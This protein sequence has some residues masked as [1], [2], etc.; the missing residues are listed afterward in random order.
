M[1]EIIELQ[2]DFKDLSDSLWEFYFTGRAEDK[3]KTDEY[4][5]EGE[6]SLFSKGKRL[7]PEYTA[8]YNL[9]HEQLAKNSKVKVIV[10]RLCG[11][12]ILSRY[13][14]VM[15]GTSH[16][17]QRRFAN[18]L[19]VA[20]IFRAFSNL[21]GSNDVEQSLL[22]SATIFAQE[23]ASDQMEFEF[24]AFL[25][26]SPLEEFELDDVYKYQFSTLS[27]AELCEIWNS[28]RELR[29]IF[30]TDLG[31][32]FSLMN[33]GPV[34]RV[35]FRYEKV[36]VKETEDNA[37]AKT[38]RIEEDI[39]LKILEIVQSLRV[40]KDSPIQIYAN[41]VIAKSF[42][43]GFTQPRLGIQ[44]LRSFPLFAETHYSSMDYE[45]L[46]TMSSRLNGLTKE[47]RKLFE[48]AA[49]RISLSTDRRLYEDSLIDLFIALEALVLSDAGSPGERSELSYRLKIRVACL[50]GNSPESRETI[51][52]KVSRGYRMRSAIVHGSG[53]SSEISEVRSEIS[54]I[55]RD[56]FFELL[57]IGNKDLGEFFKSLV[58]ENRH[59]LKS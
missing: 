54:R 56:V 58:L 47:R 23:L 7:V 12:P 5:F 3:L 2:S 35:L 29:V 41:A 37:F 36:L 21:I 17:L 46:T 34:I 38:P 44:A 13:D 6:G 26:S 53:L 31:N 59:V 33:I 40:V 52:D 10:D 18:E 24:L 43:F 20:G 14:N 16:F 49:R 30:P 50:L 55:V 19:L 27:R 9:F 11:H 45:K 4:L 39:Q 28:H 57:K 22:E 51:Y 1:A 8:V 48:L 25:T 42:L 15:V 32:V